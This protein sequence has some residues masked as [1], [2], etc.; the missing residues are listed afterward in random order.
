MGCVKGVDLRT[1]WLLALSLRPEID[2]TK[3]AHMKAT[4]PGALY[5]VARASGDDCYPS[6]NCPASEALAV[7]LFDG[8]PAAPAAEAGFL[9]EPTEPTDSAEGCYAQIT[10]EAS[11]ERVAELKAQAAS[12]PGWKIVL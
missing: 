8:V 10:L 11:P 1:K 4:V 7:D 2:L 6:L 9:A 3:E 12:K 5:E